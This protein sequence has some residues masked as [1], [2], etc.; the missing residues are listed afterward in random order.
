MSYL[1]TDIGEEH[2]VKNGLLVS[3][4]FGVYDDGSDS[5]AEG[6]DLPLSSEPSGSNYSRQ[7]VTFGSSEAGSYSGDWGVETT[8][9]FDTS[10][11]SQL[12]ID[13]SFGVVNFDSDVAGDAGTPTDHLHHTAGPFSQERDLSSVDTLDVT[14]TLTVS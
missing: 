6:D 1:L 2:V 13:G 14:I 3:M 7:S 9:T 11:S 5:V 4:D 12:S 10:D 8:V